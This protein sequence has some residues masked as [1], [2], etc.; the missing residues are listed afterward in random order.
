MDEERKKHLDELDKKFENLFK[1]REQLETRF[2]KAS[3]ELEDEYD[4]LME[5]L[6]KS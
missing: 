1:K 6:R 5:E 3:G 2:W 4:A